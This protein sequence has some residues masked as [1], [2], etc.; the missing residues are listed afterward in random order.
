MRE[1]GRVQSAIFGNP[2]FRSL[3]EDGRALFLYLLICKHGSMV[4][5]FEMPKAYAARD[6]QWDIERVSKGFAEVFRKGLISLD[7]ASEWVLIHSF[8]EWNPFENPNVAKAG[9]KTFDRVQSEAL[10][11]LLALEFLKFAPHLTEEFRK[12]LE[13]LSKPLPNPIENQNQNQNQN[14]TQKDDLCASDRPGKLDVAS[15]SS[16]DGD[17]EGADGLGAEQS[18]KA[19][20]ITER[21]IELA[22][23]LRKR[24]AA[25]TSSNPDIRSMAE[26][27]VSDAEA[28]AALERAQQQRHDKGDTSPINA[29]YLLAIMAGA[30]ANAKGRGMPKQLPRDY[31]KGVSNGRLE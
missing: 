25:V 14:H 20:A 15:S 8:L 28:L 1:Y 23:M 18:G 6:L 17:G 26:K 31:G 24:G 9:M 4:G 21:S 27:G 29:G 12:G 13:T 7:E 11:P 22:V 30:Q 2:K 5:C 10:K 16:M 19:D 3:T